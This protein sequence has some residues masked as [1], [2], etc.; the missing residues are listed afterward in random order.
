MAKN[1]SNQQEINLEDAPHRR[2]GRRRQIFEKSWPLR[3]KIRQVTGMLHNLE[4]K[5]GLL[6]GCLEGSL[7]FAMKS[8]GGTWQCTEI[9][10]GRAAELADLIGEEVPE[11]GKGRLPFEDGL[12]DA[13]IVADRMEWIEDDSRFVAECHR[14]LKTSGYLIILAAHAKRGGLLQPLR[15][16]LSV[17]SRTRGARPGYTESRLFQVIKDGFDVQEIT[18]YS[19]FFEELVGIFV[20]L[21]LR[22]AQHR[23]GINDSPEAGNLVE[24][25]TLRVYSFSYPLFWV[26]SQLDLLLFF[27]KGYNLVAVAQ[28]R[29]WRARRA[30]ILVDGRSIADA[31]INTKI[32]TAAPF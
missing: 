22:R 13:V 20:Q 5:S 32:G 15:R 16:R 23:W 8:K 27:T 21:A 17:D 31:T 1:D 4:G 11:A 28:R 7:Y 2:H 6:V 24:A 12:F 30:P 9:G 26:A 29:L 14:V 25:Q 3:A 18:T 10:K 19:R